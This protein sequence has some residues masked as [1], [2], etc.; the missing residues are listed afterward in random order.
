M[1]TLLIAILMLITSIV[2]AQRYTYL[3]G[4]VGIISS[5]YQLNESLS[6]R[7]PTT[8]NGGSYDIYLRQDLTKFLAAEI[9]YSWRNYDSEYLLPGDSY[10]FPSVGIWAHL[11][12]VNMDIGVDIVKDRLSLYASFGYLICVQ[13]YTGSGS[14]KSFNNQGDSLIIEWDYVAESEHKS[15]FTVG[16]GSRINIV[17]D[18][19]MELELGYAFAYEDQREYIFTYWDESGGIKNQTA[20]FNGNYWRVKFGLSYPIQRILESIR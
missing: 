17:E 3:G 18:L 20:I 16:L 4:G 12:P 2:T 8:I 19:L 1:R 5:K 9:G 14:N 7:S 11:I 15:L 6:I 13:Q 10:A